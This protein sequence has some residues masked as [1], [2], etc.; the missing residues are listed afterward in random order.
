MGYTNL[1]GF[2]TVTFRG[3]MDTN[4]WASGWANF[5]PSKC[6]VL[7]RILIVNFKQT[8]PS[9]IKKPKPSQQASVFFYPLLYQFSQL[10]HLFLYPIYHYVLSV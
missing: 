3:A 2:N 4:N 5:D 7:N 8:I 1:T 9:N 6:C 10:L